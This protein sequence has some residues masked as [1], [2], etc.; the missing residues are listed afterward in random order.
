LDTV[1]YY[2]NKIGLLLVC[3]FFGMPV[4]AQQKLVFTH[5]ATQKTIELKVGHR[6]AILYTGYLGQVEFARETVTDITDS[7]ITLGVDITKILPNS[8]PGKNNKLTY[9][10]ILIKDIKGFRR[11]TVGRQAAKSALSIAGIVGSFYL[12]QGVYSSDISNFNAFAISL[13]VGLGLYGINNLIFPENIKYYMQ[14]GW[15]VSV[16]AP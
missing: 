5:A 7:T 16:A 8:K 3:S 6:A 14:E 9:K 2:I 15:T 1:R 10:T 11:M 12:L 4:F 13:G